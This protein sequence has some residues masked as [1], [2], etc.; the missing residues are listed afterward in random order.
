MSKSPR[1]TVS[2]R[3]EHYEVLRRLSAVNGVS[4]SAILSETW[5]M[6]APVLARVAHLLEEANAAQLS[7]REGI[8]EATAAAA[9][10]IAPQAE[11]VLLTFDLFEQAI[12]QTI[13]AARASDDASG[14]SVGAGDEG[15]AGASL[16]PPSNTGVRYRKSRGSA[17]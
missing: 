8:R 17:S 10:E 12:Q 5:D 14:R 4:M 11:K 6:A 9:L 7:V 15:T 16:P 13:A 3:P 2:L 1:I